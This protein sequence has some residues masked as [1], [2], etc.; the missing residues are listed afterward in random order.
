MTGKRKSAKVV[1]L[2]PTEVEEQIEQGIDPRLT[3]TPEQIQEFIRQEEE[4]LAR[5]IGKFATETVLPDTSKLETEDTD[6]E[7]FT[8]DLENNKIQQKEEVVLL[9]GEGTIA[10]LLSES[11]PYTNLITSIF[12]SKALKRLV[13]KLRDEQSKLEDFMYASEVSETYKLIRPAAE[14][15]YDKLIQELKACWVVGTNDVKYDKIPEWAE[16]YIKTYIDNTLR[17]L[18]TFGEDE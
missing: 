1:S 16:G 3:M 6:T 11:N 9:G 10:K 17:A 8:I 15:G 2:V 14:T 5:R 7:T 13:I 18:I 4:M 12:I